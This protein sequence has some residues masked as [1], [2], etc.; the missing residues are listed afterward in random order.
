MIGPASEPVNRDAL[1]NT[2]HHV[3][4]LVVVVAV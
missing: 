1:N 3:Q 4:H 2:G